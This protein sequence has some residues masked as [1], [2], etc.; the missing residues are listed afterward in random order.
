MVGIS[1]IRNRMHSW[2]GAVQLATHSVVLMPYQ[3]FF[4]MPFLFHFEYTTR[5]RMKIYPLNASIDQSESSAW[6][7]LNLFENINNVMCNMFKTDM[8]F[9]MY[10]IYI[11][12]IK[13][14]SD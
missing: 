12:M 5:V 2:G 4:R 3:S 8:L 1:S 7:T 9:D 13:L 6:W 10:N 11:S 14:F